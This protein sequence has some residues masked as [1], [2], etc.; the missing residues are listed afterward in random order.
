MSVPAPGGW[1][2]RVRGTESVWVHTIV[3]S[4]AQTFP[5]KFMEAYTLRF[6]VLTSSWLVLWVTMVPLVHVHIPDPTD[7]W[8]AAQSVGAHTV[9]T[10]DLPGE[11]STPFRES[12]HPSH[13]THRTVRSPEL[14]ISIFGKTENS[15]RESLKLLV[16]LQPFATSRSFVRTLPISVEDRTINC[17]HLYPAFR[18]P[19]AA[20]FLI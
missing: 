1:L 19:P 4:V 14:N 11:Y 12:P 9:F 16:S 3:H 8:S 7:S 5:G 10:S 20:R 13:L 17:I 2:D 15:N 18:A 6:S